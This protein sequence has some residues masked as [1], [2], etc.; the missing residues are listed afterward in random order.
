MATEPKPPTGLGKAGAKLWR[1][2]VREAAGDNL[3]LEARERFWLESACKLVDRAAVIEAELATAPLMVKGSMGQQVPNGLLAELR[4]HHHLAAQ[5]LARLK[6]DVAESSGIAVG[7]AN[8]HR[9][10]ALARWT[11]AS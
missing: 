1:E 4:Q 11:G 3:V 8:R 5:M 7:G 10:A 2:I 9:A 6:T